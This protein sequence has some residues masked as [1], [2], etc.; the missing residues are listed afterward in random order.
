MPPRTTVELSASRAVEATEGGAVATPGN[1]KT[2]MHQVDV[3]N[4]SRQGSARLRWGVL[5][6]WELCKLA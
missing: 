4:E 6:K 3:L 2:T 5:R 1:G